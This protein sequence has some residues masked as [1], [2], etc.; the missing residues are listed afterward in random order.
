MSQVFVKVVS[1]QQ[2]SLHLVWR[3]LADSKWVSVH[4]WQ[5]NSK[6]NKALVFIKYLLFNQRTGKDPSDTLEN[7]WNFFWPKE[8]CRPILQSVIV[9]AAECPHPWWV[10]SNY[11]TTFWAQIGVKIF[12]KFLRIIP[13]KTLIIVMR[14]ILGQLS[15]R[16][17][18]ES[19]EKD[20]E[21]MGTIWWNRLVFAICKE[22]PRNLSHLS[23]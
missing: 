18:F 10:L 23:S 5:R 9:K 1:R 2:R 4:Q 16:L 17:S 8:S 19:L 14:D 12:C 3:L 6:G 21:I 7:L 15:P 11:K 13:K 22:P 20:H